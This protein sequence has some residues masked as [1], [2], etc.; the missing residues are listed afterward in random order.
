MRHKRVFLLLL[1]VMGCSRNPT[2]RSEVRKSLERQ[3]L[4]GVTAFRR[5]EYESAKAFFEEALK[6][7][8]QLY[9]P[10]EMVKQYANLA[11][12]SLRLHRL[13]AVSNYLET[14]KRIASQEKVRSFDLLL[15]WA[16]YLQK[17]GEREGAKASYELMLS[18][19][20]TQGEKILGRIHYA[21]FYL[22]QENWQEA[23]HL[24]D[25]VGFSLW[26][27]SDYEILG[28][29]HYYRGLVEKGE[30][31]YEK[32]LEAFQKALLYDRKA[33]NLDGIQKDMAQLMEIYR[34]KGDESRALY[35][36]ELLRFLLDKN[37]TL[38]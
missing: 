7:A 12:V 34:L 32:A 1:I 22:S 5:A 30:K 21:D 13:D 9:I 33:E 17:C 26:F 38:R 37:T 35:Y 6:Q 4:A 15:V 8:Y 24:L 14:G 10:E 18:Y 28:L 25:G 31:R 36:E 23:R 27:F 11:E 29:Y 16:R 19:A 3:S 20:R 2:L